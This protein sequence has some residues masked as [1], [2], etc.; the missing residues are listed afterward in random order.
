MIR[1]ILLKICVVLIIVI[2]AISYSGCK[3]QKKCGCGNDVIET[4]KSE[5]ANIYF[6]PSGT[7]I[8]FTLA[9]S[10]M[11][12]YIFCNPSEIFPMLAEYKSGDQL[13]VSGYTYWDCSY[14]YQAGNS[15]YTSP[16]KV[17]VVQGTDVYID[18]YGKK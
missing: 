6:N 2:P 5:P 13:L 15:S 18:L 14:V 7:N 9:S 10:P 1:K 12:S 16:Y 3:K 17:F 11:D 4:L 8:S